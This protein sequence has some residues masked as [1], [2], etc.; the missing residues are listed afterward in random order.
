MKHYIF[1]SAPVVIGSVINSINI[2]YHDHD[3]YPA[4]HNHYDYESGLKISAGE[5]YTGN[6]FVDTSKSKLTVESKFV[7]MFFEW[8]I[9]TS[10]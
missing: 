1:S 6:D 10:Y 9:F 8:I 7:S 4:K 2:I 5:L 3:F